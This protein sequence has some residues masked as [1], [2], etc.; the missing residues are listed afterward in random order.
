MG[1]LLGRELTRFQ[2]KN[3]K[4]AVIRYM[5]WDDSREMMRFINTVS[6]EDTYILLSGEQ[7]SYE[8]EAG[9]VTSQLIE[10]EKKNCVYLLCFVD[11]KLVGTF[12]AL[13]NVHARKRELHVVNVGLIVSKHV[14]GQ[15]I[16]KKLMEYGLTEIKK[17]MQG[18]KIVTLSLF[19][20]NEVGLRL[21]KN[22][23]FVEHG[24]LKDGVKHGNTYVDHVFMH[25]II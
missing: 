6:K 16:G 3:G 5:L 1:S 4:D 20:N 12:S 11:D 17:Q 24:R 19:A 14:R 22:L 21:Y 9:F 10:I 25:K 2:L 7:F 23:G 15:G 8:E 18:I 13:R